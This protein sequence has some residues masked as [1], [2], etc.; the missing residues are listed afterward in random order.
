M[1]PRCRFA[2]KRPNK[3]IL[4]KEPFRLFFPAAILASLI[5]VL[6]WP[7]LYAGWVGYYPGVA[8]ARLMIQGFVGG[9]ALGFLCTALPKM[10]GS[11]P[12]TWPELALLL[13]SFA[14][15]IL[16]HTFN[17][18][19]FGDGCFLFLWVLL[20][21]GLAIRFRFLRQDLPPPGF[22]L[23]AMGLAA[24]IVGTA[25]LL[26]GRVLGLSEFQR[27]LANLLLYEG[28]ILGPIVGVGGFLFPRFLKLPASGKRSARA[29]S[30]NR[31]ALGGFFVGLCLL[32]TYIA[33]AAGLA[34]AAP[35][36]RA[37]IVTLYL[38]W[39]VPLFR[40]G[41]MTGSLSLML[42]M[43]LACL[44][45][46]IL[47]SGV[48]SVFQIAV[49]HL[50]FIGGYGLLIFAIAGRVIWG[51]SGNIDLAEG[52]RLSLRFILALGLLAVATRI[53]AD[54][55]PAIRVSHHIYAALSWVLAAGIW[56]WAVLRY[57][58]HVDPADD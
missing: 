39:H 25:M 48:T 28:F 36:A 40:R 56:S 12:L 3:V 22:V 14:G 6:L 41:T 20:A 53:V 43:A 23:A 45:L 2:R 46:G 8:H 31:R 42:Q 33:Q 5:G 50:M 34:T 7:A 26:A 11:P 57:I 29:T 52:K 32:V 47:V 38:L 51:H 13:S 17:H 49:K 30:W 37:L 54:F 10:I 35:I 21:G 16:A 44:L 55:I 27:T 18:I 4:R 19:A 1:P 58:R 15:C 24:G 9:F